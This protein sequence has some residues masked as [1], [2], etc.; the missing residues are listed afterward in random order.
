MPD[1]V[2]LHCPRTAPSAGVVACTYHHWF[3]P[4]SQRKRYCQ[5]PVSG[6]R[7]QRF[8][9]F[10]LGSHQLPIVTGRFSGGHHVPRAD[11]IC[12]HCGPG[13]FADEL[14]VVLECPLLQ[15]LRQ[16]YADLFTS[17]TD[18]M[19]SFFG[20]KDHMRVFSFILD[21]LDFLNI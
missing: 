16:Q 14:H 11:M 19:R 3:W 9:Q 12:P 7:M 6:R 13:T 5:L 21:C 10:R 18:T 1:V 2:H 17:E 4:Y 20:Q 8:L 15:P